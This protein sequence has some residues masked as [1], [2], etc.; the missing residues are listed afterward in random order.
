MSEQE[1][2]EGGEESTA[3]C[4]PRKPYEK[5]VLQ[6]YGELTE[7]TQATMLSGAND[8]ATHPNKHFTA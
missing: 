3:S 8:G 1:R 5:P 7:M 4:E 2:S 6:V